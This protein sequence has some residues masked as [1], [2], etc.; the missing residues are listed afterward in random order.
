[1]AKPAETSPQAPP[2]RAQHA[3]P[4]DPLGTLGTTGSGEAAP[5]WQGGNQVWKVAINGGSPK[6]MVYRGKIRL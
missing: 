6:W 5:W 2:L 4:R 1:M 3:H